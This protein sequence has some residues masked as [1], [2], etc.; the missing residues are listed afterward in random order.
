MRQQYGQN[1]LVNEGIINKIVTA[2]VAV[3]EGA[4]VVEI[5]PGKGALTFALIKHGFKN[6]TLVEIDSE[7]VNFLSSALPA[8]AGVK[9]INE[10]FLKFPTEDLPAEDTVFI[11]N[12]PYIWAA[13]ILRKTLC[14]KYFKAAV[15]MFQREQARRI[16]AAQNSEFYGPISLQSQVRADITSVTR[17]SPGSFNPPPK[18][19]S[20]VLAFS[21]NLKIEEN[22]LPLFDNVTRAAFAYKRKNIINSLTEGMD[23]DKD[24]FTAAL[25]AAAVNPAARAQ[26]IALADYILLVKILKKMIN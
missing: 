15:Y 7:M 2:A 4:R 6:F 20:E 8:E 25:N 1:F 21:K 24:I 12:L 17:V 11:S 14:Y 3:S 16:T 23:V 5:G 19:E 13:E 26:E 9:I 10:D 18:V 22:L